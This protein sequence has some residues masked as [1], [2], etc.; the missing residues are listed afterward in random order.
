MSLQAFV[1]KWQGKSPVHP[2]G[3]KGEC[4]ALFRLYLDEVL[5]VPQTAAVVGAKDLWKAANPKYF[6]N[7]PNT[8]L[9]VPKFGDIVI[10]DAFKGNPYGHVGIVM[11]ASVWR[12]TSFDANF[13][14]PKIARIEKHGYLKPRC[15]GW[16]RKR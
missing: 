10:F 9:G 5:G 14:I 16:L 15:I 1:S 6:L 13:S 11:R 4:V 2:K 8:P 7:I 3:I 12:L